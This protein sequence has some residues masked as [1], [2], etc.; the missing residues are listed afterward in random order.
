[1]VT[2]GVAAM[3]A[4]TSAAPSAAV[5]RVLVGARAPV[6]QLAP[7]RSVGLG[8]GATARTFAQ[9]VGGVPVLGGQTVVL[10]RSGAPRVLADSTAA[11]L[12]AQGA[13]R[14]AQGAA[15]SIA[16]RRVAPSVL[17]EPTTSSLAIDPRGAGRLVWRVLVIAGR[18]LGDFEVLVNARSGRVERVR[19]LIREVTGT[20]KV[21][22]PNPVARNHGDSGLAD[23][24]GADSVLL[25]N[26]RT[27]VS[28]QHLS[29]ASSCL[30]G[31]WVIVK[32][33][34]SKDPVCQPARDWTP[35]TRSNARFDAANAYYHLDRT[36]SYL[37]QLGF[38]GPLGA[39][40]RKQTALVNN[41]S[42][43]NS[44]YSPG[45]TKITFG[46]GDVDDAEDADVVIH[47]YGHAIQDNQRPGFGTSFQASSLG[48]GFGD[49]MAAAMSARSPGTDNTDDVCIFDW[50]G[51]GGWGDY[52]AGLG[53]VCGRTAN[54]SMTLTQAI[55]DSDC[56]SDVHCVGTVWSSALWDL[57]V[58]LGN[59]GLGQSIMDRNVVGSQFF[60]STGES[61]ADAAVALQCTD[62]LFYPMGASDCH[63][64]H[65]SAIHAE[66]V[67]RAIL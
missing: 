12:K 54:N 9:K 65:Y 49:Y 13:P 50:D 16:L 52:Y 36:Q 27:T 44:Y 15:R 1:M 61:F 35:F 5:T 29:R 45:S 7:E 41:I 11:G 25:T 62:E 10:D 67:S 47:E 17:R 21:F 56:G 55:N 19:N 43:D 31:K 23:N 34:A 26:L 51:L 4:S 24:G 58:L 38:S 6:T 14:I 2:A 33:G 46:K 48:E 20:A 32:L 60:Y 39:N 57:H 40:A 66:M 37:Q 64:A 3:P 30:K 42:E 63:G 53:R 59:D 8:H 22:D 28:L 18:P